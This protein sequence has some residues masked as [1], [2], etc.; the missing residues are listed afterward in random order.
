MFKKY[1]SFRYGN[2]LI[3]QIGPP[4]KKLEF[5][6]LD[7]TTDVVNGF[8]MS[9]M[10]KHDLFNCNK[11]PHKPENTANRVYSNQSLLK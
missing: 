5:L 10:E 9:C 4:E 2:S 7:K 3:F 11:A 8:K 6:E 1:I